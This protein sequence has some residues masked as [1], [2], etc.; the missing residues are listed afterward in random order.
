MDKDKQKLP[1]GLTAA[2]DRTA[3][4]A[5]GYEGRMRGSAWIG[6]MTMDQQT[7]N[8]ETQ[9]KW[10]A[11]GRGS[12]INGP[13]QISGITP[14]EFAAAGY[15]DCAALAPFAYQYELPPGSPCTSLLTYKLNRTAEELGPS[16]MAMFVAVILANM[17]DFLFDMG[18]S[19][20]ISLAGYAAATD[21]FEYDL[22]QAFVIGFIDEMAKRNLN[23]PSDQKPF[24]GDNALY[25]TCVWDNFNV[26][27]RAWERFVKYTRLLQRSDS[28]TAAG[29][30][31]N[32]KEGKIL[33]P[34][35]E[36]GDLDVA[37]RQALDTKNVEK[38]VS[39]KDHTQM[40][41]LSDPAGHLEKH[42]MTAPGLCPSCT[43]GFTDAFLNTH[44]E[45]EAIP[46]LP[47][48]VVSSAPVALAAAIRRGSCWATTSDCCDKCACTI[49]MWANV[50]S[51]R[52]VV[53]LM[54]EER[55]VSS[56]DWLLQN[57]LMGCVAFSPLRL[58]SILVGFDVTADITFEEGAMG[59]R[60]VLDE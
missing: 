45:V 54:L 48:T 57:Y 43:T 18:C 1:G 24:Y 19:S 41:K 52:A 20:R 46:G 56:R 59:V 21:A 26:R 37:F 25:A 7:Y 16:R 8:R 9:L 28:P 11:E 50:M 40:Y 22:P 47:N 49:G 42:C 12:F 36:E 4:M 60:D 2:I 3:K 32:A 14:G 10:V 44:D 53:A 34:D 55:E 51:D 17:H 35:I 13:E 6:M 27:Y 23:G 15:V 33:V 5:V 39:R 29:L 58:I 30:L 31:R 38:L